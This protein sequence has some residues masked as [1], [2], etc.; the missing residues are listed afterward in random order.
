MCS[1]LIRLR[2]LS[3]TEDSDSREDIVPLSQGLLDA[4]NLFDEVM[5]EVNTL[6][7]EDVPQMANLAY[8]L[9]SS[10]RFLFSL[11]LATERGGTCF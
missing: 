11:V 9:I 6:L 4:L 5:M 2:Q 3:N 7:N 8:V 10:L 1:K